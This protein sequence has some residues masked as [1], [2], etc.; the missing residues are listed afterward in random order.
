[1]CG[2]DNCD[3]YPVNLIS[4]ISTEPRDCGLALISGY[5]NS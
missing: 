2:D 4:D 1:L 3:S 5:V